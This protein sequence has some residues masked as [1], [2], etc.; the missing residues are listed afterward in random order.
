MTKALELEVKDAKLL[1]TEQAKKLSLFYATLNG[2][3]LF[4]LTLSIWGLKLNLNVNITAC[5]TL[6]EGNI[7][8]HNFML[9][10]FSLSPREKNL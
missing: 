5:F 2:L 3:P 10:T 4:V 9:L 8:F 7:T 6:C 1:N